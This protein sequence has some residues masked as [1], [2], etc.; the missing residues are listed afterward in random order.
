MELFNPSGVDLSILFFQKKIL[1]QQRCNTAVQSCH[2]RY[3]IKHPLL[4]RWP[5][6]SCQGRFG[7]AEVKAFNVAVKFKDHLITQRAPVYN[8]KQSL[9]F[10]PSF[11]FRAGDKGLG[12]T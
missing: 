9:N 5:K 1:C 4:D 3:F 2:V 11:H 7:I 8:F 10:G 6:L 12:E